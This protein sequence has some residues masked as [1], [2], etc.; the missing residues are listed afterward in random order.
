M[1]INRLNRDLPDEVALEFGRLIWNLIY[2]EDDSRSF[3]AQIIGDL[4]RKPLED[5]LKDALEILDPH[6]ANRIIAASA[7]WLKNAKELLPIRNSIMHGEPDAFFPVTASLKGNGQDSP[8]VLLHTHFSG[9][10][11]KVEMSTANLSSINEQ[12]TLLGDQWR[13]L[14]VE[15]CPE[16]N[17]L[18][19]G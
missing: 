15:F 16:F 7:V 17:K 4:G 2:L 8:Q 13:S 5:L 12:V 10:F 11:T 9:R 19:R 6:M 14:F 18:Y 3:L 1:V